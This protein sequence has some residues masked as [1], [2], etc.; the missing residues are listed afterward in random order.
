MINGAAIHIVKTPD[1]AQVNAG[2]QIGFTLTVYNDG[3]G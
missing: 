2:E 3:F 1:A